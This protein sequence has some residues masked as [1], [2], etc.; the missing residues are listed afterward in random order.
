M[1]ND[2]IDDDHELSRVENGDIN[3]HVIH[4]GTVTLALLSRWL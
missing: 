4:P 3:T 2:V 1:M